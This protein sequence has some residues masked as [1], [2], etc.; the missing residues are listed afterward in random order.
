MEDITQIA[1]KTALGITE[2]KSASYITVGSKGFE[3]LKNKGCDFAQN[4]TGI[5]E[6]L[7]TKMQGQ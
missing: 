3:F 7:L 2:G 4:Y 5:S 6:N 1:C